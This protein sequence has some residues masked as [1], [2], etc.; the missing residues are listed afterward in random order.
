MQSWSWIG[1]VEPGDP[2]SRAW[3][4]ARALIDAIERYRTI[5]AGADDQTLVENIRFRL[6][7][8]L[9]GRAELEPAGSTGRRSRESEALALLEQPPSEA[10][11]AAYWHLLKADLLR[12]SAKPLQAEAELDAAVRS[13][14]PPPDGEIVEVR[15]PLQLD[16]KKFDEAIASV[17]ASRLDGPAKLLWAARARLAQIAGLPVG[18][19]RFAA[20]TDLFR[21]IGALRQ[22][23]SPESRRALL[24]LAKAAITPDAKHPPEVWDALA[25]ASAA[26]GDPSRAAAQAGGSSPPSVG[27]PTSQSDKA[28]T[29]QLRTG[30]FLFQAGKLMEASIDRAR[31]SPNSPGASPIRRWRG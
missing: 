6:A 24:E 13:T 2:R 30:G 19:E 15:V 12:A 22:G 9:A 11:L 29:Y 21:R 26:A 10:G 14:P 1:A 3:R 27:M 23:T 7:E 8:A 28:A 25:A 18:A 20:E 4:R 5:A 17:E 31:R 16:R